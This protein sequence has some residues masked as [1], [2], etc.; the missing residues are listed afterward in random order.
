MSLWDAETRA[1]YV[2]ILG[3]A[4]VA[5][6]EASADEAAWIPSNGPS[7]NRKE[8]HECRVR[9]DWMHH[10][11]AII[12]TVYPLDLTGDWRAVPFVGGVPQAECTCPTLEAAMTHVEAS[13]SL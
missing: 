11:T 8:T 6:C 10:L 5:E 13:G 1:G 12:G 7:L 9:W 4:L 3:P 2:E